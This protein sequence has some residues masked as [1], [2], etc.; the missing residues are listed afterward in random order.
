MTTY[1]HHYQGDRIVPLMK[2]RLRILHTTT[3]ST[4]L[5]RNLSGLDQNKTKTKTKPNKP[6]TGKLR[7]PS[8]FHDCVSGDRLIVF[9]G[10]N[11]LS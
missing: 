7:F 1:L 4:E 9:E 11:I 2:V 5:I 3:G 6:L 8:C 10:E